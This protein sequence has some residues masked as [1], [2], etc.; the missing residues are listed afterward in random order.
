M[1]IRGVHNLG[2]R[3]RNEEDTNRSGHEWKGRAGQVHDVYPE[4]QSIAW[5]VWERSD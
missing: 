1:W 2:I 4:A 3:W 5:E